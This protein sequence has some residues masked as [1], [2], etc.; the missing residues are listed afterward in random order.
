VQSIASISVIYLD[1]DGV[2]VDFIGHVFSLF[3]VDG[4]R[5]EDPREQ[6]RGWDGITEGL[7]RSLGRDVTDEELWG[8]IAGEGMDFWAT[9]PWCPWG[10]EL[11]S[12]CSKV[13]PVVIMSTPT[14]EPLSAAGKAAWIHKNIN[15]GW[16]Y[17]LSP[18][19]HLMAHSRALLID[20]SDNNADNFARMG[21]M[22]CLFP[23]PWNEGRGVIDYSDRLSGVRA[24]L[25]AASSL[26]SMMVTP[27]Q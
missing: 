21:G 9:I 17:A 27:S 12:I 26:D 22:A 8:K 19:K 4:S 13:A 16:M 10:K 15:G 25:R 5:E 3:G 11:L 18:C 2:L 24:V 14:R 20:D 23:Q 6:V 7:S 1:M